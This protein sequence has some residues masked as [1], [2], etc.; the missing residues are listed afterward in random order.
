M[1]EK[2]GL[3]RG[4]SALI[5]DVI[6]PEETDGGAMPGRGHAA[7]DSHVPIEN[8]HPN[9]DQPRHDFDREELQ[10]LAESIREKGILQ[11]LLVRA[12]GA[13]GHYQ[14][15]AGERRWRAAQLAKLHEVPVLVRSYSDE[16][17]L[18]IALIE[19][20]QRANL[21]PVEEAQGYRQLMERFGHTQE[22]LA[23]ALSKSRSH[24]ANQMR[25]LSLPA[26]VMEMLRNGELSAG[27][28]RAIITAEDPLALARLIV[29]QGL[30]VRQ[31]EKLARGP[32]A[33]APKPPA[34]AHKDADTLALEGDLTATLGMK[35]T[36]EQSDGAAGRMVI[37]YP[38]LEE[39]DRLCQ[40]LSRVERLA[41]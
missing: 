34:P 16:Q 15:V 27:H 8:V 24:I 35:V 12:H 41:H 22:Q 21:N 26:M 38:S 30:S 1:V 2:R 18:E 28:A 17:V 6:P 29:R 40:T 37:R 11:P 25:L 9:P 20:V 10:G 33:K 3:G 7:P 31:A 32:V 19:N 23:Q 39:L 5:G 36:I 4:L 14:I 13:V